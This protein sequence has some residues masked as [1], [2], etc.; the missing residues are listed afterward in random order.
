[1]RHKSDNVLVTVQVASEFHPVPPLQS[2]VEM[3]YDAND[4]DNSSS[5]L[6]EER[7]LVDVRPFLSLMDP[8][9][10]YIVM[11]CPWTD[12]ILARN[13]LLKVEADLS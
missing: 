7:A 13:L 4:S 6:E 1:M 10:V 8:V 5:L 11:V 2:T 12:H 9:G 3:V